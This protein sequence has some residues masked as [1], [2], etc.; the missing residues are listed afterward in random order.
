MLEAWESRSQQY[1]TFSFTQLLLVCKCKQVWNDLKH[2]FRELNGIVVFSPSRLTS[3]A[4][5]VMHY[6]PDPIGVIEKPPIISVDFRS[7]HNAINKA[8]AMNQVL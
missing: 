8:T 6:L 5:Q 7:G 2:T 3:D 1:Y 4:L